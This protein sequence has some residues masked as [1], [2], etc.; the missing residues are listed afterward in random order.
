[1]ERSVRLSLL[2]KSNHYRSLI[3]NYEWSSHARGDDDDAR[4][5]GVVIGFFFPSRFN[6][7]DSVRLEK[8]HWR[9]VVRKKYYLKS[10]EEKFW[11]QV[12]WNNSNII[13]FSI[14]YFYIFHHIRLIKIYVVVKYTFDTFLYWA[15]VFFM[16]TKKYPY[17]I[18]QAACTLIIQV[19]EEVDAP[20]DRPRGL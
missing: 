15:I 20:L 8:V 7:Y 2:I 1:M 9:S 14:Y 13:G 3:S 19:V 10:I 4:A 16:L 5:H 12:I 11:I 6:F 18:T 17:P